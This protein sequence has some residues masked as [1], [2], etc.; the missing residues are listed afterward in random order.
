MKDINAHNVVCCSSAYD[1]GGA[2]GGG[3]QEFL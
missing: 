2:M 3:G 1:C